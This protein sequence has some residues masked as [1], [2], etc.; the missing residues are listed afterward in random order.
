MRNR[1]ITKEEYE[2]SKNLDPSYNMFLQKIIALSYATTKQEHATVK[3]H[4]S[5]I[6]I[7]TKAVNWEYLE[8]FG[9]GVILPA[10]GIEADTGQSVK[11]AGV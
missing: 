7:V 2:A 4:F 5:S 10:L 8:P 9:K 1:I 3:K 6:R 11:P